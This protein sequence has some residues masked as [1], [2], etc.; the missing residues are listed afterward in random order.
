LLIQ[1]NIAFIENG[2]KWMLASDKLSGLL[3]SFLL[4]QMEE[5]GIFKGAEQKERCLVRSKAC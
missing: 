1:K 5:S 2:E 4:F 3:G